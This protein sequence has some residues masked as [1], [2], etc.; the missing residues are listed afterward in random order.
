MNAMVGDAG[1]I[2][3]SGSNTNNPYYRQF[4]R[5]SQIHSPSRIFVFIEEHPDSITDAYF[6]NKPDR[7][8]WLDLPASYHGGGA[9]LS[10][11]DGHVETHRWLFPATKP[12]PRPDAAPLP[13]TIPPAERED[14]DWLMARTSYRN[15][16]R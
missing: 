9:N 6:L 11:A 2:S 13:L 1:E 4:F 14:F 10:F 7:L 5:A 12:P 3:R 16:R 8:E 15:Y